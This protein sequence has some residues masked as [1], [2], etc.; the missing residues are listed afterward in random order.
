MGLPP[1]FSAS[2][3]VGIESCRKRDATAKDD[4]AEHNEQVFGAKPLFRTLP[5]ESSL[6]RHASKLWRY[7]LQLGISN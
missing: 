3:A 6:F 2:M 4:E 1:C 5:P 7:D